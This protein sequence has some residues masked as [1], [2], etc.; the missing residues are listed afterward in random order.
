[1]AVHWRVSLAHRP[2]ASGRVCRWAQF[3]LL[4]IPLAAC[5][6]TE[7]AGGGGT[8]PVAGSWSY[9]GQQNGAPVVL[10]GDL[11]L[12]GQSPTAFTGTL[13]V[14]EQSGGAPIRRLTGPLTGRLPA[15]GTAEFDVYL[16]TVTRLHIGQWRS[17]TISGS[18]IEVAT[19]GGLGGATGSFRAIRRR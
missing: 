4:G 15:S 18:W 19:G 7:P 5:T 9:E 6:P 12:T 2:R 1:M 17:D 11:L 3:A 10:A 8:S 14:R 13:D 16:G